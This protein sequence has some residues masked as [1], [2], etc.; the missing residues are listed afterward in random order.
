MAELNAVEIWKAAKHGFDVWPDILRWAQEGT[1]HD[2]IDEPDLQ[3]LLGA[4]QLSRKEHLFDARRPH[5]VD[6][7]SRVAKIDRVA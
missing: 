5:E 3:R 2:Q 4:E 1:P 7:P 6:E